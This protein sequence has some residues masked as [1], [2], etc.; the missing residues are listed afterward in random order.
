M[1]ASISK[2]IVATAA[3]ILKDRGQVRLE[4]SA[5][6]FLHEF[7]GEGRDDVTIQNLLTHTAGLP[8]TIPDLYQLQARQAGLVEFFE[9]TCRVPLLFKPGSAVSYSNLGV[10]VV[11]EIIERVTASPLK[12][13]LKH[14]V[15]EPLQMSATSLGL[16]GAAVRSAAQIQ[17]DAQSKSQDAYHRQLGTPWGGVHSTASDMIRFLKYFVHPAGPP[18][19]PETAQEM[20]QNHCRG[21]NQPWGIGWMLS[22][23]HDVIYKISPKWQ[24][25]RWTVFSNPEHGAAFGAQ[26]S[27]D[28]FGHYGV[29]GTIAWADP[30][31]DLSMVLLT[32]KP[33]RYSR[34]GVLGEVSDLVSRL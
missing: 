6:R 30:K 16:E 31:R 20:R 2:P 28:T 34:E 24:R 17:L 21:L 32:T 26:C 27:A 18:L 14:E 29:L 19:K 3:M 5:G 8:D 9:S 12:E 33:V 1:I 7:R 15:F 23:S 4:D 13:F 10:L 25:Y 11:K 22:K